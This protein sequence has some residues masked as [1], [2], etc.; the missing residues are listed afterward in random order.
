MLM[1]ATAPKKTA[2]ASA[3]SISIWFIRVPFFPVRNRLGQDGDRV[4]A[5]RRVVT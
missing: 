4:K 3:R 5:K 2:R 1:I